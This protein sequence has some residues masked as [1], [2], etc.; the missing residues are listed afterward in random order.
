[1]VWTEIIYNTITNA[2]IAAQEFAIDREDGHDWGIQKDQ[3]FVRINKAVVNDG[4][5]G[6]RM[7]VTLDDV[8]IDPAYISHEDEQQTKKQA[9]I[10]MI[11]NAD[12]IPKIQ[13]ILLQMLDDKY[14]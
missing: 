9:E 2:I 10:D 6:K 11:N 12:T 5:I 14:E 3:A 13:A 8:E 1:M 4:I 7:N